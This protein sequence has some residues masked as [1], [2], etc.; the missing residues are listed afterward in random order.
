MKCIVKVCESLCVYV[1]VRVYTCARVDEGE[2]E[3]E[4]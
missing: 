1:C 3:R 2:G 4:T